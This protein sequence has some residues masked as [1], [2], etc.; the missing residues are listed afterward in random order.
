MIRA[1]IP[2]EM[3]VT[4][5]G[6]TGVGVGEGEPV[7]VG[8]GV[9]VGVAVGVA[10]G[11]GVGVGLPVGVTGRPEAPVTNARAGSVTAEPTTGGT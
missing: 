9:G 2:G 3:P 1:S 7:G 4:E 6:V 8:V 5:A 10:V 11:L